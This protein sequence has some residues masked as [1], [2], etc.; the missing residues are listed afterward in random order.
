MDFIPTHKLT[1]PEGETLVSLCCL[2]APASHAGAAGPAYTEQEWHQ[3]DNADYER[4][5]DGTWTFQG[6][7][8]TGTVEPS[9]VFM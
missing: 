5:S 6:E 8:F 7:A 2:D 4:N 9:C 3:C 1:T